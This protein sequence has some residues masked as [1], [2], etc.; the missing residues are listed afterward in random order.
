M[1]ELRSINSIKQSN[2]SWM[3][4]GISADKDLIFK[5]HRVAKFSNSEL[6]HL[7]LFFIK[8][9]VDKAF[10]GFSSLFLSVILRFFGL[11]ILSYLNEYFIWPKNPQVVYNSNQ[12]TGVFHKYSRLL[13]NT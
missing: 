6:S 9:L 7:F 11:I 13:F 10:F 2:I 1:S 4:A 12:H 8:E 5:Y 3:S